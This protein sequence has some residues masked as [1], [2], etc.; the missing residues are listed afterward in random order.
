VQNPRATQMFITSVAKSV[1]AI[2]PAIMEVTQK[3]Q[4]IKMRNTL[5]GLKSEGLELARKIAELCRED[6]FEESGAMPQR[7]TKVSGSGASFNGVER[8]THHP[9]S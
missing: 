1:E 4:F 2:W 6:E 3:G 5:T 9:R 8:E 7:E